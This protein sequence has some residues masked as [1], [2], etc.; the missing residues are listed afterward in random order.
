MSPFANRLAM[1]VPP[2]I[3]FLRC[4]ANYEALRFSAPILALGKTLVSRM[5]KKSPTTGGKYISVHLRFEE[6]RILI[7]YIFLRNYGSF[8]SI[9]LHFIKLLVT[10]SSLS[11]RIWWPSRVVCMMGERLKSQRWIQLEKKGGR[12]NSS[13]KI[14]LFH[15]VKTELKGNVH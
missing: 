12:R 7:L 11:T 10:D 8:W 1:N 2:H 3:Q 15:L 5:A 6:V 14:V 9:K 13:E 4:L